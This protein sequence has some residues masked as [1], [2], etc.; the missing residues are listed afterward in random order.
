MR[1]RSFMRVTVTE[2]KSTP[3]LQLEHST[4]YLFQ[5]G[6]IFE[7]LN[8]QKIPFILG[9][10]FKTKGIDLRFTYLYLRGAFFFLFN[11]MIM[12]HT[13]VNLKTNSIYVFLEVYLVWIIMVIL[14]WPWRSD[15]TRHQRGS[16][17]IV[18]IVVL[19]AEID[20]LVPLFCVRK[21]IVCHFI[22]R[23]VMWLTFQ[24]TGTS[25]MRVIKR[26]HVII[27]YINILYT[28]YILPHSSHETK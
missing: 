19:S 26:H 16:L 14:K 28:N 2:L 23:T 27:I 15:I 25:H 10:I 13:F 21:L 1:K 6:I 22:V 8:F 4:L 9:I 7:F 11:L 3:V 20:I 5:F 24:F 12:R 18:I 17:S